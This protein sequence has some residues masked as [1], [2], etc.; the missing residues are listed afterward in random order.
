MSSSNTTPHRDLW[1]LPP[2][3]LA[4]YYKRQRDRLLSAL[5]ECVPLAR[6]GAIH[7]PDASAILTRAR[8]AIANASCRRPEES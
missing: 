7:D 5:E 3:E 1:K 2:E 4:N 6:M 8:A